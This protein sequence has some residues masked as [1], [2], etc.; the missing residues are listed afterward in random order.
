MRVHE[1]IKL[2]QGELLLS[3]LWLTREICRPLGLSG[4]YRSLLTG[5]IKKTALFDADYYL[6]TNADV[7]QEGRSPLKHYLIYGDREGRAPMAFFDPAYYR[8]HSQSRT[9]QVN[10]LLHYTYVGRY[11]RISTSPWFD[12]N[13]YLSNNKDVARAGHD[14]LFHYLKWGGTEGRSPC[15]QFDGA[16]YLRTNADVAQTH[17]NPLIHY[18]FYGRLEGRLALPPEAN[19]CEE[20]PEELSELPKPTLPSQEAWLQLTTKTKTESAKINIIVP[21]YKGYSETLRC[22]YSVLTAASTIE[23]ELIVINDASPDKEL[24][25]ELQALSERGLFTLLNNSENRGFIYTC[26][27]GMRLHKMRDVVLLNSDTEVYDYWLDRLYNVAYRHTDTGTVTPLS[28]NA[29]ICS[30]PR[31]LYDN[32]FPLEIGY[33]ELDALTAK[34]NAGV[35]VEAPTGVGFCMYI[36]RACLHE[37]GLLDA[38]AFGRGY[39]EENDFCQ[40]AIKKGWRN[41]IAADVFV[42]HWGATSFQGERA[43]RVQVA[44][45]IL[46][47][48]YPSYQRQIDNFI[49][50]NTLAAARHRLDWARM[51]N[52]RQPRNILIVCHNR[53]GGTERHVQ[54]DIQRLSQA[55]CSVFLLR[56]LA[57]N[58]SY[59]VL[60][61]HNLRSIP[62][63]PPF[64]FKAITTLKVALAEL[65]ITE[66]H[67]HS[68]V[69]FFAD[70]PMYLV[71]LVKAL[72]LH[73]E[74]NLHDYEMICPRVNL[75]DENGRYCGEPNESTCNRCL[76]E[77]DSDFHVHNI[78]SWRT[79]HKKMLTVADKIYVPNQDVV[80]RLKHYFPKI[81]FEV[82]PHEQIDINTI[83][84][85]KPQL[86]P[87]EKL[88][89]VIIGAIGK[90]KGFDVI[91]ACSKNAQLN[92]LPLEFIILGYSMNESLTAMA[93]VKVTGKY[94]EHE[95]LN[96][97]IQLKPHIVWLPSLWPETYS[98]TLSLALQANLHVA[99]FDIGAIA[100][101]LKQAGM[102]EFLMDLSLIDNPAII[103]QQFEKFRQDCLSD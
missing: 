53:G 78:R 18:L 102:S 10:S 26:N 48:R 17:S 45:K 23:Y 43:K 88:R 96:K 12:V 64:E 34:V 54:E 89:I 55:G 85:Q 90:L 27:R 69:D 31:F 7:A 46:A 29:T 68:L 14:P 35:E 80:N 39:G 62:N 101:R 15:P 87:Q 100:Q 95:A 16:Y 82:S 79:T 75:A 3:T 92:Q 65:N 52:M 56:P 30:Y 60:T 37:V 32:P 103:N 38:K 81:N 28:N 22:L 63:I 19:T 40:R 24:A 93:G 25:D 42:R 99:A 47:K 71:E 9:K 8:A 13:Y 61:H 86:Q 58:P 59:A 1:R 50:Q 33:A 91:L 2:W 20:M 57:K 6:Q 77:R 97:L 49:Q 51:L 41:I 4:L 21:V 76:V 5:L 94:Q 66:I 11:Q 84:L 74:V 83:K 98:Y 72:S 36:K 44:L 67:T 73:C 70:A